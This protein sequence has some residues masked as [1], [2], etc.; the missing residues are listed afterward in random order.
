[1]SRRA[2]RSAGSLRLGSPASSLHRRAPTSRC[3][4]A[5]SLALAVR[6]SVPMTEQTGSPKFLGDPH[7]HVPRFFDPG[8]TSG[9][10]PPGLAVPTRRSSG[11]AFRAYCLVGFHDFA[12]FGVRFRSPR[13]RCLRFVAR[14]ALGRHARLA[15][16]WRS[17]LGRAG[18]LP[19]GS[20]NQ[21]SALVW[22]YI[23]SS[24][25]RLSWRTVGGPK[26]R[27]RARRGTPSHNAR[28]QGDVLLP[29]S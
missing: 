13:A 5:A 1:M 7:A 6:S 12:H 23:T 3:T 14:V 8:G 15:S 24:W 9:A 16:G 20:L 25:S 10:G 4:A 17:C 29:A 22:V 26:P 27:R 28:W 21:V 18:L 2:L 11:V 19:A